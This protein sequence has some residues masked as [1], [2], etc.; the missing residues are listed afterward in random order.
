MLIGTGHCKTTDWDMHKERHPH[1]EDQEG[2][3]RVEGGTSSG[4]SSKKTEA[5]NSMRYQGVAQC[6]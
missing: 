6:H 1:K 5:I 4:E 2:V 3:I